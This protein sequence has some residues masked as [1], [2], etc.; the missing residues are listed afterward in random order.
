MPAVT[1]TYEKIRSESL[2]YRAQQHADLVAEFKDDRGPAP[3]FNIF[4][5]YLAWAFGSKKGDVGFCALM[6]RS[7]TNR[8]QARER[9]IRDQWN[10]KDVAEVADQMPSRVAD[11]QERTRNFDRALLLQEENRENLS[12]LKEEQAALNAKISQLLAVPPTPRPS[13]GGA[14]AAGA[15]R[16]ANRR[17]SA[18]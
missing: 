11:I 6:C 7:A 4:T 2:S 8:V 5:F 3:P 9:A 16:A 17:A 15:S 12:D 1:S 10:A 14:G 13:P 18:M